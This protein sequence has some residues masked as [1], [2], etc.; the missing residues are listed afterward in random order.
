MAKPKPDAKKKPKREDANQRAHRTIQETV[1]ISERPW[2]LP[3]KSTE[4][5]TPSPVQK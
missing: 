2:P 5:S 1:E 4:E 3:D